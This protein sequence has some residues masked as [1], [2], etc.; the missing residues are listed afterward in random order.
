MSRPI[1]W[2]TRLHETIRS[3]T[4]L[5]RSH[6]DRPDLERLFELRSCAA[7]KTDRLCPWLPS[8][9]PDWSNARFW[10]LSSIGSKMRTTRPGSSS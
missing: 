2:L 7:P 9:P 8:G 3:V 4:D 1:S 10:P 5:V 6:Y